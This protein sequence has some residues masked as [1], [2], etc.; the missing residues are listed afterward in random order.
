MNLVFSAGGWYHTILPSIKYFE[1]VNKEDKTCKISDYIVKV[2]GVKLG[3]EC[4][5]KHVNTQIVFYANRDKIVCHLYNT[6]QLILINGNGYQ[7]FVNIFLKPFFE[8]M[9]NESLEAIENMND[10]V[11]A[12]LVMRTVKR[13]TV[14]L[15]RVAHTCHNCNYAGKTVSALKKHKAIEHVNSFSRLEGPRE[16]TRNNSVVEEPG[17]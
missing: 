11:S 16:S 13:L 14:K 12:K 6:T 9:I 4:N 17:K 1:E 10:E 3:K 5:G 7:K 8:S 15:K 2:S